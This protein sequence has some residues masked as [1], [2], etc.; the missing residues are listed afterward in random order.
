MFSTLNLGCT[1][2]NSLNQ[3]LFVCLSTL[4]CFQFLYTIICTL[5]NQIVTNTTNSILAI[6]SGDYYLFE[7]MDE[8]VELNL[9]QTKP[10]P[11]FED[12]VLKKSIS[13]RKT[14]EEV[15]SIILITWIMNILSL[16]P[17]RRRSFVHKCDF[18]VNGSET[19]W[20]IWNFW[21]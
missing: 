6:L 11:A 17:K 3:I 13:K 12:D 8:Q 7:D 14:F 20:D 9:L 19:F 16:T 10:A 5:L 1:C 18:R 21:F 15:W 4:H 2:Y